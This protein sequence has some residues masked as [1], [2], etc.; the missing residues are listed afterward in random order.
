MQ[1][2]DEITVQRGRNNCRT[3]KQTLSIKR[4]ACHNWQTGVDDAAWIEKYILPP[5]VYK[6]M[7]MYTIFIYEYKYICTK[8]E[9]SETKLNGSINQ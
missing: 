4:F 6:Y 3:I 1:L 5:Y 2:A 9:M 8:K 7:Y